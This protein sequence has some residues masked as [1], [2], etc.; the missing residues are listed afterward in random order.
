MRNFFLKFILCTLLIH[1]VINS[2][3]SGDFQETEKMMKKSK[4]IACL[5]LTK[6]R[7]IQ[8]QVRIIDNPLFRNSS[9]NLLKD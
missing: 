5:T 9:M 7:V 6:T 2:A 1:T 4:V 8:D 3:F